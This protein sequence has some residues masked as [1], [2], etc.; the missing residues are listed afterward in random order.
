MLKG[1]IILACG[2]SL[3][4]GWSYL[5]DRPCSLVVADSAAK[6]VR[7]SD[8]ECRELIDDQI[9]INGSVS[10]RQKRQPASSSL[11]KDQCCAVEIHL[12]MDCCRVQSYGQIV[13]ELR[14]AA[15]HSTD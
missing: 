13:L 5:R 1:G 11:C 8:L 6:C 3:A 10:G 9:G 4:G 14:R 15:E 12:V 7:G 2:Q